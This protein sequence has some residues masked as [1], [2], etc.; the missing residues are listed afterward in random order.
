MPPKFKRLA[1]VARF[2]RNHFADRNATGKGDDVDVFVGDHLVADVLR[3]ACD[4]LKHLR[5]QAGFI[6]DIGQRKAGQ[7]RQLGRLAHHAIVGGD[8]RRNFVADHVQR[9]VEWRDRRNGLHRLALGENLAGFAVVGQIAG[10]NL[11]VV[12]QNL[13]GGKVINVL[14]AFGLVDRVL[15][16]DAQLKRQPFGQI[17]TLFTDQ[18]RLLFSGSSLRS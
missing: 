5:W 10:E 2:G 4:N 18:S 13:R 7:G 16:A 3:H 17:F 9:V 14:C 11:A 12:V 6:Q 8:G 15:M 1:F